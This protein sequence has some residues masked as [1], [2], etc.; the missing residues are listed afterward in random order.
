MTS[1]PHRTQSAAK[2]SAAKAVAHAT[3]DPARRQCLLVL[4]ALS[5]GACPA[6]VG[7]LP[8]H[9]APAA[10]EP[11]HALRFPQ[12]FGAHPPLR[13]EWWYLT[14]RLQAAESD[15]KKPQS[16][17]REFGF[18]VTFFRSRVDAAADSHS[19]FA[20]KQL[21]FAHTALTDLQGQRLLHDQRAGRIGFGLVDA[22]EG[23]THVSLRD[24]TLQRSGPVDHSVYRTLV[25]ARDHML[26]LT[27]TQTQPLLRQ[28]DAG[29]SRKGPELAQASHY[30]SQPQL[31]VQGELGLNGQT[32]K[33]QGK[34]W[35]DH[36]WSEALLAADAV[37]W[38]WIGM[39]L[40]DGSALTAFRLRHRDGRTLWSGGSLRRPGEAVRAFANGEVR[41]TPQRTWTSPATQAR[42][43]V[44]WLID[45]PGGRYTVRA[46]LDNQELD[47]RQSTGSVYWEGL[48]ELLN[49]QGQ[50]IGSGYLEMTGYAAPLQL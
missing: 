47:S 28:G 6:T 33:V 16:P 31:T 25:T 9:I 35:L 7:A 20:A 40:Q 32:F 18:Q 15:Q 5:A 48:S 26:N 29:F 1:S 36:E 44:Q 37:G 43:P 2:A 45:I 11:G 50:R 19:A 22:T 17:P 42:Y 10:I 13:T 46:R 41:F 24:W 49:L 3:P 21:V 38:D 27:C 30:Y 8:P 23:D 14:G 39:N 34:A 4:A 12:D